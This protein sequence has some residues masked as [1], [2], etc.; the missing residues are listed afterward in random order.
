[1]NYGE[2]FKLLSGRRSVRKYLAEDIPAGEIEKMVAAAGAAPSGGNRQNWHF[3]ALR[4]KDVKEKMLAAVLEQSENFASKI[5]SA[6]AKKEFQSYTKFYDFF[7]QAP[8]VVAV[9]KKP[10]DS[11]TF[12]IMRRYGMPEERQSSADVQG[13]AAAVQNLLLAAHALGYGACW[14]TGPMI[15]RPEL[16]KLL[17]IEPPDELIAI[18]PVGKPAALTSGPKKKDVKEILEWL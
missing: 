17:G 14:M 4:S 12:R 9:V 5:E 6:T 8:V 10:Y 7:T 13:P 2:L 3:I 18:I 1:M 15:A 16:E 11:L